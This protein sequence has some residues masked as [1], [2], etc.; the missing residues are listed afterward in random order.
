VQF[1]ASD[2]TTTATSFIG[3]CK[4]LLQDAPG[5]FYLIVDGRP[6]LVGGFFADQHLR[7]ITLPLEMPRLYAYLRTA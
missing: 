5:P 1:A 4:R 6:S 7:Y 2:G 3:F